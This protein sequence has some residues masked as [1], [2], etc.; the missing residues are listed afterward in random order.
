MLFTSYSTKARHSV[1]VSLMVADPNK[2]TPTTQ[3]SESSAS[4]VR[5]SGACGRGVELTLGSGPGAGE[6]RVGARYAIAAASSE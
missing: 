1:I 6:R 2:S 4:R 5:K 3:I